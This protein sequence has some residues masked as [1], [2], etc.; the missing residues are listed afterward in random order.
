M[1]KPSN[2]SS[3]SVDCLSGKSYGRF[4]N[5]YMKTFLLGK[6]FNKKQCSR[7]AD[8]FMIVYNYVHA[9]EYYITAIT[10]VNIESGS[11]LDFYTFLD[12]QCKI[13]VLA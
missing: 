9:Y 8:M 1:Q 5:K 12:L 13:H 10:A 4:K 6:D 3:I 11:L 7:S 2:S